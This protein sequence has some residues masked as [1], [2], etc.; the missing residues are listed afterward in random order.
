MF[1]LTDATTEGWSFNKQYFR[2]PTKTNFLCR[3]DSASQLRE[4]NSQYSVL[5]FHVAKSPFVDNSKVSINVAD[6]C[7]L[8]AS[9]KG[10]H[11]TLEVCNS[12]RRLPWG[13]LAKLQR[14]CGRG[15]PTAS[16]SFCQGSSASEPPID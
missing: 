6:N 14:C 15:R 11:P 7:D 9:T 1:E 4:V 8:K 5:K 13:L 12:I 2:S 3:D 16:G 10:S